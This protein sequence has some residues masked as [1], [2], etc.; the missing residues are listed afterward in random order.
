MASAVGEGEVEV[1]VA[2]SVG[3]TVVVC[4]L[5]LS[6]MVVLVL[7]LLM[8]EVVCMVLECPSVMWTCVNS[9]L[10][11]N[12]P[13][14]QLLVLVLSLVIPLTMVLC[15]A[16]TTI[17]I[18]PRPWIC[19]RILTLPS[20]GSSILSRTRLQL[21]LSVRL[22]VAWLL[23]VRLIRQFLRLSLSA[24]KWVTPL[25]L[26]MTRTCVTYVFARDHPLLPRPRPTLLVILVVR[27]TRP[28]TSLGML[29]LSLTW[30]CTLK[31]RLTSTS[32]TAVF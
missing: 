32:Y 27:P 20:R 2:M 15:V 30:Q 6:V 22:M 8:F 5:V 21:C 24:I 9:L 25:L 16:I 31:N 29:L 7:V 13:A 18:L 19:C 17:G 14:R 3:G 28:P 11:V 4:L 12:G 23:V 26:L 10:T 1:R